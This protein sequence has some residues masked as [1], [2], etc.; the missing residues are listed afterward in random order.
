[1]S[2]VQK[3]N[4]KGACKFHPTIQLHYIKKNGDVRILLNDCP[5]CVS[6]LVPPSS[7]DGEM[8]H[9]YNDNANQ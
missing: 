1:M 4:E 6:G 8:I 2:E 3:V 9:K 5:L 7:D